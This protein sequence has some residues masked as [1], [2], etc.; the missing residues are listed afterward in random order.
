MTTSAHGSFAPRGLCCP[1]LH[2]TTT[3][4]AGLGGSPGFPRGLVIPR[5]FARRRGLGCYRDCPCFGYQSVFGCRPAPTPGDLSPACAQLLQREHRPSHNPECL[6]SPSPTVSFERPLG[7]LVDGSDDAI[8]SLP[9]RPPK[10]L[11]PWTDRP[12]CTRIGPPGLLHPS[13][14]P[15]GSPPPGVGYHYGAELG[16]LRRRVLPPQDRQRYRL[17]QDWL[18]LN[19]SAFTGRADRTRVSA[20]SDCLPSQAI[21]HGLRS[22]SMAFRIVRSLRMAAM[23][24]TLPGRPA[25]TRR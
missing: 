10:L 24:A 12:R 23:T 15:T 7:L 6:A 3:R 20:L 14:L 2:A 11:A 21:C 5:V 4:S 13:L 8:S 1:R 16:N 9:L 22:R 17:H 18:P 25:V 19:T